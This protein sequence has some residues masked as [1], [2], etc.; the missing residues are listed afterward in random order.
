MCS[1]MP[2]AM[3]DACGSVAHQRIGLLLN[4]RLART[5]F[6]VSLWQLSCDPDG[7]VAFTYELLS[8]EDKSAWLPFVHVRVPSKDAGS[9]VQDVRHFVLTTAYLRSG[10]LIRLSLS[11]LACRC[12]VGS[13]LY[14]ECATTS[15]LSTYVQVWMKTT[16]CGLRFIVST[17]AGNGRGL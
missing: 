3:C 13:V 4:Y 2:W 10:L 9:R 7:R 15:S 16:A 12:P 8:L 6:G 17:T 11:V 14:N 1:G 5:D